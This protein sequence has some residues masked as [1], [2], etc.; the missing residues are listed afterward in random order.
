[1]KE[2]KKSFV[3]RHMMWQ[4]WRKHETVIWYLGGQAKY[5]LLNLFYEGGHIKPTATTM[6]QMSGECFGNVSAKNMINV[7]LKSCALNKN[8][9]VK[10]SFQIFE[11]TSHITNRTCRWK[12]LSPWPWYKLKGRHETIANQINSITFVT[13][14][15]RWDFFPINY[16]SFESS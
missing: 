15:G 8:K 13:I 14:N 2:D 1:M 10:L 16:L 3:S 12:A 5:S 9:N 7:H 11:D 6:E 4:L